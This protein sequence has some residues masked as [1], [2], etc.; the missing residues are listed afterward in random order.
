MIARS[1]VGRL[2]GRRPPPVAHVALGT[3]CH[4]ASALR[5]AGL[6]RW[7]GPFD[8]IFSTPAMISACLADDFAAFL[9]PANL[10]SVAAA[11]LAHGAKRQGR[12]LLYEARYG[13][14]PLFNHHDPAASASDARSFGRA[15]ARM[16]ATLG[17]GH[18]NILYMMSEIRWPEDE[19]AELAG[20]LGRTQAR[21][22]L[23]ILTVEGGAA[24][25]AWTTGERDVEGC[26]VL[27]VDLRTR[28][29][30]TGIAF[31]DPQ[32]A[33][34]LD[35]VLREVAAH[36]D[37]ALADPAAATGRLEPGTA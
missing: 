7:T 26:R 20:R 27:D 17:P 10:A 32:D 3:F 31:S 11:D 1:L 14:P 29:R 12:H 8:W 23:A 9:D 25:H 21:N 13:L 5:D 22:T 15:A 6:R 18:R 19:I 16:R 30:S 2:I 36:H 4:I 33:P 35:A 37:A 28:S 24:D 34:F